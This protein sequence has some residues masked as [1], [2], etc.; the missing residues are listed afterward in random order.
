MA[1]VQQVRNLDQGITEAQEAA[2]RRALRA[3]IARLERQLSDTLVTAYADGLPSEVVGS[4]REYAVP[5][6]ERPKL[7]SF[8]E[9]EQLRD[10]L[11]ARLQTG[12]Q[13]LAAYAL[14][15][16]QRRVLLEQILAEPEQ[17]PFARVALRDTGA[18]NCGVYQVRPRLGLVGMLRG[19][20]QVKLSSGCPLPGG[21]GLAPR[22]A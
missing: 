11:I 16:E 5:V 1:L 6:A 14:E 9:L 12:R 3:Q 18:R 2:A 22:P 10:A 13:M 17:Y 8:E 15:Q 20:W 7:L 19:W 21:R 4:F